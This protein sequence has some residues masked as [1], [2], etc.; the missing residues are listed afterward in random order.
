MTKKER[1]LHDSLEAVGLRERIARWN[2]ACDDDDLHS[3]DPGPTLRAADAAHVN[4]LDGALRYGARVLL[5]A[6]E[7][8]PAEVVGLLV[9]VVAVG[10]DA[11]DAASLQGLGPYRREADRAERSRRRKARASASR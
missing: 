11:V 4:M 5:R 2:K 10:I 7:Q 9:G 8:L 6:R 3:P 1:L